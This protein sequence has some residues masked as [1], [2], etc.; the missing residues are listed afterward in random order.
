MSLSIPSSTS[1]EVELFAQLK[2]MTLTSINADQ[3]LQEEIVKVDK[4]YQK[5]FSEIKNTYDLAM[6]ERE[7]LETENI[8]LEHRIKELRKINETVKNS[9]QVQVDLYQRLLSES[10]ELETKF[11]LLE[12]EASRIASEHDQKVTRIENLVNMLKS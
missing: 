10:N 4:K 12:A 8:N 9:I 11:N 6:K 7:Q 2:N 3:L 1:S 5:L